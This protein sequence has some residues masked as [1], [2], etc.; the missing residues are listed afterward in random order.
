MSKDL[1]LE[2]EDDGDENSNERVVQESTINNERNGE[3][4]NYIVYFKD[5]LE[6]KESVSKLQLF[7]IAVRRMAKHAEK[8]L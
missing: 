2:D 4:Q 8:I 6:G 1:T 7:D 3:P 5:E